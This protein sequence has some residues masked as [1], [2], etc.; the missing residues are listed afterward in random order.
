MN[1]KLAKRPAL[2]VVVLAALAGLSHGQAEPQDDSPRPGRGGRTDPYALG[3]N[4][5]GWSGWPVFTWLYDYG[6][7]DGTLLKR[8]QKEELGGTSVHADW[9]SATQALLDTDFYVSHL[10]S[11]G[12]LRL[13]NEVFEQSLAEFY[14]ANG[15]PQAPRPTSMSDPEVRAQLKARIK[16]RVD[17]HRISNPL[18]YSLEDEISYTRGI[19]PIDFRWDE[20]TLKAFRKWLSSREQSL[21]S[22]NEAWATDWSDWEQAIPETTG[23]A[24]AK[25][26]G[27]PIPELN[28]ASWS[29]RREFE[30]W[31]FASLVKELTQAARSVDP[32]TPVGFLGG[33]APSAFGGFDWWLLARSA[34]FFEAYEY[35]LAP[36]LI[37]AF[38]TKPSRQLSTLFFAET[39][40]LGEQPLI[41]LWKRVL[42]GDD[43]L[44]LNPVANLFAPQ[45]PTQLTFAAREFVR[46]M[47]TYRRAMN[48]RNS[49]KPAQA[50]IFLYYSQPS[51]RAGWMLDS[52]NDGSEWMRRTTAYEYENSLSINSREGWGQFLREL[53]L[54]FSFIDSRE[55]VTIG[56]AEFAG[57]VIVLNAALA[58]SDQEV[59]ELLRFVARGGLLIADGHTALFD[60][61][62]RGRDS[63]ALRVMFGVLRKNS[64]TLDELA[65]WHNG[66]RARTDTA[67]LFGLRHAESPPRTNNPDTEETEVGRILR[68]G[69][70]N[71]LFL[72]LNMAEYQEASRK[73]PQFAEDFRTRFAELLRRRGAVQLFP[74][75]EYD[76]T[77]RRLHLI[78]FGNSDSGSF[79]VVPAESPFAPMDAIIYFDNLKNVHDQGDGISIG[80]R[81]RIDL[82]IGRG[83]YKWVRYEKHKGRKPP[84]LGEEE[85]ADEKN[86]KKEKNSSKPTSKPPPKKKK[87]PK[88][89][90][91]RG[92]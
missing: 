79:L 91:K 73:Q 28:F 82:T 92:R 65:S 58:L 39:R 2:A 60:E 13:D 5:R 55:F 50:E 69:D 6:E 29:D 81:N 62:L 70:G 67:R 66:E 40:R 64:D 90:G 83:Q 38:Q 23:Q 18:A 20:H 61:R 25:N 87:S 76:N 36:E 12:V 16:E 35:G 89:K 47:S 31:E 84:L 86:V 44:I 77:C 53:S 71:A 46:E 80:V 24:R 21:E 8:L 51:I 14:Q 72:N 33:A 22:L 48:L 26:L 42:R 54:P 10:V 68:I 37:Q 34:S 3:K 59:H 19:D 49:L 41:E 4:V 1:A 56:G 11:P 52:W 85:A 75:L 88:K 57:K 15:V 74:R 9:S 17:A 30:E 45:D 32:E 7:P 27:V 63:Q 43:G 78:R